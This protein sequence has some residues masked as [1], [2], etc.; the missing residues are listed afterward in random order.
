MSSSSSSSSRSTFVLQALKEL[1][2]LSATNPSKARAFTALLYATWPEH[3]VALFY[4]NLAMYPRFS[5]KESKLRTA[6]EQT[7]ARLAW[8]NGAFAEGGSERAMQ[9]P[10]FPGQR[11]LPIAYRR[12]GAGTRYRA[13]HYSSVFNAVKAEIV[14]HYRR[15]LSNIRQKTRA[16][17]VETFFLETS[18]GVTGI[19]LSVE[20]ANQQMK[21]ALGILFNASSSS[22]SQDVVD[23]TLLSPV[24]T[25]GWPADDVAPMRMRIFSYRLTWK[26]QNERAHGLITPL[27]RT[28]SKFMQLVTN[29]R[30][31]VDER[32]LREQSEMERRAIERAL[33]VVLFTLDVDN[34][35]GKELFNEAT[36]TRHFINELRARVP[37]DWPSP[38]EPT[39]DYASLLT[40][41]YIRHLNLIFPSNQRAWS[42][43]ITE[44]GGG[45]REMSTLSRQREA[46]EGVVTPKPMT[47]TVTF[48][49]WFS[50]LQGQSPRFISWLDS[51]KI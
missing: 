1:V 41:N 19:A 35:Y 16:A 50:V 48:T 29:L 4:T 39:T 46:L 22:S 8:A 20:D 36:L 25:N 31:V 47:N 30:K 13:P 45:A 40:F 3:A 34:T 42:T 2:E 5:T 23:Y 9:M 38:L 10:I 18:V 49:A 37:R 15:H 17:R 14:T 26:A 27:L 43:F 51:I 24:S 21:T 7:G 32:L 12:P 11:A 28:R 44:Y 6:Y 33:D